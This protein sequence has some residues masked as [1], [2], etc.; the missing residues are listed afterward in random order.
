MSAKSLGQLPN[1]P[2]A[3]VLGAV[4]FDTQLSLDTHLPALQ[5]RLKEDY[6][7]F[8]MVKEIA[9]HLGG[10]PQTSAPV[11]RYEFA[12]DDNRYGVILNQETLVFHATDYQGYEDFGARLVSVLKHVSG[13]LKSIFVRRIGLRYIDVIIPNGNESPDEYVSPGLRCFP[14]LDIPSSRARG[15]LAL[16]EIEMEEGAL[17]VRYTVAVGNPMLPPDVQSL[18]LSPPP[19]LLRSVNDDGITATLD[20]DRYIVQEST[21][22]AEQIGERFNSLHKDHSNA[23]RQLTTEHAMKIWKGEPS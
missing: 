23:F 22:N 8:Q 13:V 16:T 17:I 19:V 2:L 11:A 20:F 3:Y 14:K 12:S 4:K 7:R 15:G 18:K 6:P 10:L 1:A 9:I 5:E 21:F